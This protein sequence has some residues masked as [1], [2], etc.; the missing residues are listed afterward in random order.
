MT[1][2]VAR[3]NQQLGTF[4]KEDV[5]ARYASGEILP[6]DLVWTEGMA[7]WQPASQVLGAPVAPPPLLSAPAGTPPPVVPTGA[8]TPMTPTYDPTPRPAKPDNYL[9][10]AI[11]TTIL[12]CL[13]LGIISI[14]FAAQVDSKYAT[15]DYKGAAESSRKAKLFAIWGAVGC[16]VLATIYIIAMFALGVAGAFA[17]AADNGGY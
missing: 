7:N 12:C 6:T 1:Y 2:H 14:I 4:S 13:P 10:W 3:N 16:V 17:G 15:G 5:A 11:L 8:A 9:V